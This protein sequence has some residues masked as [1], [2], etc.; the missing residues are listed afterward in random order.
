MGESTRKFDP[1]DRLVIYTC[2]MT[3]VVETLPNSRV[4]HYIAGQLIGACHFPAFNYGEV[5]AVES[6]NDF[7]HKMRVVLKELKECRIILKIIIL[8]QL[9]NPVSKL[10]PILTETEELIAI[11]AKGISTSEKRRR[12][13]IIR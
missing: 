10:K 3:D 9:I 7:L 11:I 2:R 6:M 5:R 12:T 8:K 13:T 1:E 4:D